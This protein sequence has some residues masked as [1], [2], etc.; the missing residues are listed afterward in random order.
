M[1]AQASVDQQQQVHQVLGARVLPVAPRARVGVELLGVLHLSRHQQDLRR[2]QVREAQQV[3]ANDALGRRIRRRAQADIDMEASV[4]TAGQQDDDGEACAAF[5]GRL[6]LRG[7][8]ADPLHEVVA[9]VPARGVLESLTQLGQ[10]AGG[11]GDVR[12]RA[13]QVEVLGG[14]RSR[15]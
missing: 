5:G 7:R 4:L 1:V 12:D 11:V 14:P 3:L 10:R 9:Q 2:R 8:D 13:G 6:D 15:S